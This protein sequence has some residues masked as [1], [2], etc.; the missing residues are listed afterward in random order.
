MDIQHNVS[1]CIDCDSEFILHIALSYLKSLNT[2]NGIPEGN[3]L[4]GTCFVVSN[5][6]SPS[7]NKVVI[8]P[9]VRINDRAFKKLDLNNKLLEFILCANNVTLDSD[10]MRMLRAKSKLLQ[11]EIFYYFVIALLSYD[12][13]TP[14][15]INSVFESDYKGHHTAKDRFHSVIAFVSKPTEINLYKMLKVFP[16]DSFNSFIAIVNQLVNEPPSYIV[17]QYKQTIENAQFIKNLLK[18]SLCILQTESRDE[19]IISVLNTLIYQ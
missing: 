16:N 3:S 17:S 12:I 14:E 8:S 19:F 10:L 7:Y 4:F 18:V 15:L 5:T 13:I 11:P 6:E 9:V 1:Y 2:A